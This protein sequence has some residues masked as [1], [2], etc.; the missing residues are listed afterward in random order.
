MPQ[1]VDILLFTVETR[2]SLGLG[3]GP[4]N[5]LHAVKTISSRHQMASLRII[6]NSIVLKGN[7]M[8]LEY[9]HSYKETKPQS[10][11][12]DIKEHYLIIFVELLTI[13]YILS[14]LTFFKM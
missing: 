7:E 3:L 4:C 5:C 14:G 11:C 6:I 13:A 10:I 12:L 1:L 9:V 8:W 2:Q